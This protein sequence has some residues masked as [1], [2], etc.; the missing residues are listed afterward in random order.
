METETVSE[1]S[2]TKSALTR[3]IGREHFIMNCT[4]LHSTFYKV[5]VSETIFKNAQYIQAPMQLFSL[6]FLLITTCFG[7]KR[8]SSDVLS[9]P[10]LSHTIECSLIYTLANMMFLV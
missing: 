9:T 7:L 3:L 10:K 2:D 6:I 1:T 4:G 5:R 8:S